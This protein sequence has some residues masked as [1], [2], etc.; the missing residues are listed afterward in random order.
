MMRYGLPALFFFLFLFGVWAEWDN[1]LNG[2]VVDCYD[3]FANLMEDQ[4]CISEGGWDSYEDRN[5][6][7][8]LYGLAFVLLGYFFGR[9]LDKGFGVF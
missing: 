2:T 7:L 3:R 5:F 6:Q 9:S 8:P 1:P 4:T